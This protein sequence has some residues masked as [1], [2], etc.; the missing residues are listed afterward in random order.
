MTDLT[1]S[2]QNIR[3]AAA[4]EGDNMMSALVGA[5]VVCTADLSEADLIASIVKARNQMGIRGD[6]QVSA[7]TP[8]APAPAEAAAPAHKPSAT[9]RLGSVK[10]RPRV[11]TKI[12]IE[13]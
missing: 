7:P 5:M 11:M 6:T 8:P 9:S 1:T 10:V 12:K 13:A 2:V 4:L 3:L